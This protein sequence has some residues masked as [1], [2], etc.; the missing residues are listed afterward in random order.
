MELHAELACAYVRGTWPHL[1]G[2][3]TLPR[4]EAPAA[5]ELAALLTKTWTKAAFEAYAVA[6]GVL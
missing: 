1:A 4:I 6:R 2:L 5:G 3:D